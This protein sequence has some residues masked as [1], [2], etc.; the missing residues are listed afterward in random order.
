M[1]LDK[2]KIYDTYQIFQ[3]SFFIEILPF[4]TKISKK[5]QPDQII[6]MPDK[7]PWIEY[8]YDEYVTFLICASGKIICT[9]IHSIDHAHQSID[10]FLKLVE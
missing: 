6:Y 3:D 1:K 8:L 10:D 9:G 7:N 4:L 2:S 5:L